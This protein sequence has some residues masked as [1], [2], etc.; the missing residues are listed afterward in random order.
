M[1]AYDE[2]RRV[3]DAEREAYEA[4]EDAAA[5]EREAAR[6]A[7]QDAEASRWMGQISLDEAGDAG[8][9]EADG[10]VRGL[11]KRLLRLMLCAVSR[12]ADV[13]ITA[14]APCRRMDSSCC[15]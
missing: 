15:A 6:Q 12:R 14:D 7:A 4:A 1:Q 10:P 13:A 2:K 5:A 8:A 3:K 9:D 11:I